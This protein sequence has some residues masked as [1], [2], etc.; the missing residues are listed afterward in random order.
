MLFNLIFFRKNIF[1]K[2]EV[3]FLKSSTL[4]LPA[5]AQQL[6]LL[7]CPVIL[8]PFPP[9]LCLLPRSFPSLWSVCLHCFCSAPE[10][11]AFKAPLLYGEKCSS[12]GQLTW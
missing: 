7:T 1:L 2:I 10:A 12:L 6:F 4:F 3:G 9:H 5:A 8:L 11:P